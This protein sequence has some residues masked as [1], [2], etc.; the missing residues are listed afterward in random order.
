MRLKRQL[1]SVKFWIF[2]AF[3]LYKNRLVASRHAKQTLTLFDQSTKD[4]NLK[5]KVK[6]NLE[7]KIDLQLQDA[8]SC[9]CRDFCSDPQSSELQV[10]FR[11]FYNKPILFYYN[12]S[13]KHSSHLCAPHFCKSTHIFRFLFTLM[14][15]LLPLSLQ[16]LVWIENH[17]IFCKESGRIDIDQKP[18]LADCFFFCCRSCNVK[19]H[20]CV[21][22]LRREDCLRAA[23]DCVGTCLH[24]SSLQITIKGW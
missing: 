12:Y 4:K 22:T 14:P 20:E 2:L 1:S 19:Y 6:R 3:F 5:V 13:D 9:D 17:P 7:A 15:F 10:T 8:I 21:L 24:G 23:Y 18:Y 11:K 16:K